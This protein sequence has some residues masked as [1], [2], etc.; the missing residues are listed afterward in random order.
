MVY[1]AELLVVMTD[2]LNTVRMCARN[3]PRTRTQVLIYDDA[4]LASLSLSLPRKQRCRVLM[5]RGAVLLKHKKIVYR[6][7]VHVHV[8]QWPLSAG[9]STCLQHC[10]GPK[11][12]PSPPLPLEVGPLNPAR[13]SG[14]R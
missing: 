11:S 8:W 12:L 14:E 1:L 7:P 9:A 5:N 2:R 4:F 10:E 3:V 13:G 6:Q